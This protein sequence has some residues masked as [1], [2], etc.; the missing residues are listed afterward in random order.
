ML[1]LSV[2][3]KMVKEYRTEGKLGIKKF[4]WLN[5]RNEE[6]EARKEEVVI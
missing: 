3:K 6:T 5:F 1:S 2:R 4:R